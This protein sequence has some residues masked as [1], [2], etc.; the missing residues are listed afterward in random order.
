MLHEYWMLVPDEDFVER[1]VPEM[2]SILQWFLDRL[3]PYENDDDA[4]DDENDPL[5]LLGP[6]EWWNFID[7]V[8]GWEAGVPPGA[9]HQDGGSAIVS[10]QFVYTLHKAVKLLD[11]FGFAQRAT[12]YRDLA[13]TIATSVYTTCWHSE[14]QL[15]ADTP[16][17]TSFSQHA[18]VL[19]ILTG[20]IP[21][22]DWQS[23]MK[24]ILQ[25]APDMAD[26]KSTRLNSSH[27][28]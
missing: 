4:S 5:L 6:L 8:P 26:R 16:D 27:L 9:N 14:R 22:R 24:R 28:A 13:D 2:F 7:W 15:L 12:R 23:V 10:L 11:A 20:S 21:Q 25:G 18:N 1:L 17:Q 19:G 3:Q